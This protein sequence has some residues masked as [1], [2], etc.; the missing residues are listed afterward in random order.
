[1]I[2]E[3]EAYTPGKALEDIKTVMVESLF[4]NREKKYRK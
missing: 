3:S 4:E 2:I 1:M